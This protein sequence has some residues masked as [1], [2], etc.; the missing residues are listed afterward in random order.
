MVRFEASLPDGLFF[1]SP[2]LTVP[3]LPRQQ[4]NV[5]PGSTHGSESKAGN[6]AEIEIRVPTPNSSGLPLT[7][8][9][10][11]DVQGEFKL[12]VVGSIAP[13]EQRTMVQLRNLD[14]KEADVTAVVTLTASATGFATAS[15]TLQNDDDESSALYHSVPSQ[16][17]EDDG[18]VGQLGPDRATHPTRVNLAFD[19]RVTGPEYVTLPTGAASA[20]FPMFVRDDEFENIGPFHDTVTAR[21]ST[22]GP[23]T[24]TITIQDD[25]RLEL[26][27][28]VPRGT[29]DCSPPGW[30]SPNS[31]SVDHPV[32]T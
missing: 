30:R 11:F 22:W 13:G 7:S 29:G 25:E 4:L 20:A 23:V 9:L 6:L 2:T 12:P 21:T 5:I 10:E 24:S 17:N 31:R 14:D 18:V 19:G 26:T 28:N 15:I 1:A 16:A 32:H 8:K 3:P 27:L